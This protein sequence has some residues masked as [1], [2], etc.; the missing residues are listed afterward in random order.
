MNTR[1]KRRIKTAFRP[2]YS[3]YKN[4]MKKRYLYKAMDRIDNKYMSLYG[5]R[6]NWEEPT[7]Y[8]EIVNWLKF[9]ED[10]NKWALLAD[11]FRVREYVRKCGLEEILVPLYGKYDTVEALFSDWDTL[12]DE[13]VIKSNNG[14]GHATFITKE[15]GGKSAIDKKELRA[16][17]EYW[18]MEDDYGIN[19]AEFQYLLIKN[20]ILVE[21]LLID[22][23]IQEFSAAPI[24]YKIFCLNGNPY[25]CY[26]S[27]GRTLTATGS[28]KRTGDVY[29]LEWNERSE[30]MTDKENRIELPRPKN[31]EKMLEVASKLSQGHP[32]ARVDLYNIDGK[33]YFGE[34]TMTNG[35]GFDTE[36]K[37]E[38]FEDMGRKIIL[39][40]SMPLN[41]FADK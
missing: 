19:N 2:L 39:D 40:L 16:E 18:L 30:F 22:T 26:T 9:H 5:R 14:C 32:Q 35:S 37:N 3:G 7:E 20:C 1:T 6:I 15:N 10:M 25:V 21:K 29:D 8:N 12:P 23:T 27:Y 36:F 33:V 31:W 38:L 24:D 17:I 41:Q 34:I 4:I 11:K 28:H 13:F